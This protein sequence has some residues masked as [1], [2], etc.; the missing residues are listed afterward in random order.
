MTRGPTFHTA[1]L[2]NGLTIVGE[3]NLAAQ[4]AAAGFFVRTGARDES[5]ELAGVSHFLEHM[6]FKGT[7]QRS[8]ED[9]NREFDALGARY[10]A[11]TSGE[12]TVY[13]GAVLPSRFPALID[14]LTD[15]MR[16]SLRQADFDLEK[17][18]IL[19]E[20]AMYED[21][22]S[23][24]VFDLGNPLFYRGHPLGN[25]ILGSRE[26]IGELARDQMLEYFEARYAP[27]NLVL[28]L[29]GHFDW[30]AVVDQIDTVTTRWKPASSARRRT[31]LDAGSGLHQVADSTLTRVHL[32]LF[33]PG[34]AADDPR[35]YPAALLASSLGDSVGSR[36]YWALVDP[37]LVDSAGLWHEGADGVGAF[38]GYVSTAPARLDEVLEI[39][40]EV[41]DDMQDRGLEL[42]EWGSAQRKLA[43]GL[44]LRGETPF[45]RLMSLGVGY[46]DRGI[47]ESLHDTVATILETE[48]EQ[49]SALLAQRPFDRRLT[50]TLGPTGS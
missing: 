30:D 9:I 1:V 3:R 4:T 26:T 2:T 28:V 11:Y 23:S 35:R 47:Y 39:L 14:L 10:N 18:V 45:G 50:I 37:G 40:D 41:L 20:I 49:G 6:M 13:F 29:S 27:N 33:A 16:P 34:F 5:P 21:R 38:S 46:L 15:M 42:A 22:P 32:A 7:P 43:T 36:L 25:N 24:R 12:R 31:D 19:E 44:T 17:N 8:A 48:M